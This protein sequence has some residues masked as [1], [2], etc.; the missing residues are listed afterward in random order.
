LNPEGKPTRKPITPGEITK[1]L[2]PF[3][4][5]I[6]FNMTL[7]EVNLVSPAMQRLLPIIIPCWVPAL[8]NKHR[9][10]SL[11]KKYPGRIKLIKNIKKLHL[12]QATL[13]KVFSENDESFPPYLTRVEILNLLKEALNNPYSKMKQ[14]LQINNKRTEKDL[15]FPS[16]RKESDKTISFRGRTKN[17]DEDKNFTFYIVINSK[18]RKIEDFHMLFD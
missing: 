2:K 12:T 15:N 1:L 6:N 11:M 3:S 16:F 17:L 10:V 9:I 7:S 8:I 14:H 5:G 4:R 18:T 13:D